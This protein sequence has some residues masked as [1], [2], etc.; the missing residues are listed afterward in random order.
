MGRHTGFTLLELM[1]VVAI[2]GLLTAIGTSSYQTYTIRAQ[3]MEGINLA[4]NAKTP[5]VDA[6]LNLGQAPVNRAQAGLTPNPGDTV[7]NYVS[8]VAIADGRVD[9]I[10]GN[11]ANAVIT[12]LTLSLTPYESA[13]LSVVWRCGNSVAPAGLSTMGTAGGGVAAVYQATTV[14]NRYLPSSCRP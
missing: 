11:R 13:D 2:L 6:F 8:G 10:F 3:V 12:G 1:I 7:G 5:I 4:A 14:D 9:I